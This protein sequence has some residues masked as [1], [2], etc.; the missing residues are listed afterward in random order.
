MSFNIRYSDGNMFLRITRVKRG[1]A[2]LECASIAERKIED[3]KQKT[4]TL[5]L[6]SA[7]DIL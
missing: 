1:S 7:L 3:G 4:V 2:I 6:T 5:N